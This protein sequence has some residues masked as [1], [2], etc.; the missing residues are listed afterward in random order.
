ME[1]SFWHQKWER[2]EIAFHESEANPFL[3]AHFE[4]LKLAKDSRGGPK[5]LNRYL[6]N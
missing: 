3:V 2:S 1:A 6:R 5:A 4:K